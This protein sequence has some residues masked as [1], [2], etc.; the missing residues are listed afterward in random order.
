MYKAIG[1][2]GSRLVRVTWMLEELGEAYEF[3]PAK[4]HSELMYRYNPSGKAPALEDGDVIIVDSAAIVFYLAN[5]HAD[6]GMGGDNPAE[7]GEIASW[8]FFAQVE[9]EAPLWNKLKHRM[10]LPDDQRAEVGPWTKAEFDREVETFDKRLGDR[11][12]AMGD[13]FTCA[14]VI[15][16]H[17]GQWARGAKFEIASDR[18]NAYFDRVLARPALARAKQKEKEST[19]A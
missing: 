8:L 14:D 15:L 17:C 4:Q 18:V 19:E 16:G 12:F 6:K 2:P 3:A 1:A 11:Q 9:L 13:R 10:M 7:L 5:K